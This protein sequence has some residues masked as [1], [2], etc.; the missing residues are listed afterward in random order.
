MKFSEKLYWMAY[1]YTR[2]PKG[3]FELSHILQLLAFWA[4]CILMCEMV[5]YLWLNG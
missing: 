2:H 1:Y 4:V 5:L 3:R